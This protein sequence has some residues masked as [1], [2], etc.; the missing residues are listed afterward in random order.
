M[1]MRSAQPDVPWFEIRGMRNR[2]AHDYLGVDMDVV[3]RA[4]SV[5]L[6][7]LSLTLERVLAEHKG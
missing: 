2:L 4:V 1:K 6:P 3:W 5:E 7:E